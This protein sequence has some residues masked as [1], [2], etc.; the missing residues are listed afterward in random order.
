MNRPLKITIEMAES[1]RKRIVQSLLA[2]MKH[3]RDDFDR[4]IR[5][6]EE[7]ARLYDPSG[8]SSL[9]T[10]ACDFAKLE[11]LDEHLAALQYIRDETEPE[12]SS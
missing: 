11:A 1:R 3:V 7:N 5:D 4:A 10:I 6:L 2:N 8:W 9:R 12:A